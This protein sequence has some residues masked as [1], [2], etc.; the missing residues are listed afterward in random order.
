M[1][2]YDIPLE[3]ILAFR[4]EHGS[5]IEEADHWD[6]ISTHVGF[7]RG[8]DLLGIVRVSQEQNGMLPFHKYVVSPMALPGSIELGIILV[9]SIYRHT[10]VVSDFFNLLSK[11]FADTTVYIDALVKGNISLASYEKEGAVQTQHKYFSDRYQQEGV[12]LI[13]T[14]VMVPVEYRCY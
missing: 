13:R 10:R 4:R 8:E 14:P 1:L 5:L 12:I 6:G 7:L 11:R 9:P 3:K 2:Q